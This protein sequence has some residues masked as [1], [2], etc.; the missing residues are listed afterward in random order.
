MISPVKFI[1]EVGAEMQK[2]VWPGPKIV[3]IHTGIVIV[4]MIAVVLLMGGIDSLLVLL[5]QKT[6]LKG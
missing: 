4:S 1:K 6:I 2:V 5:I 3:A